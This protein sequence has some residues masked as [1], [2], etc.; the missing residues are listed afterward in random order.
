LYSVLWASINQNPPDEH[1]LSRVESTTQ[2]ARAAR[3]L[4]LGKAGFIWTW[5][6]ADHPARPLWELAL[7]AEQ[8][9][10]AEPIQRIK[11][12]AADDCGVLF[13]DHSRAGARRWCSMADCG[14]RYKVQTF[15]AQ[16]KK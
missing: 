11:K 5:K 12:C 1:N 3:H 2:E 4:Q 8:L 9:L 13:V 7:S 16:R 15:R 14:N 10:L 6:D